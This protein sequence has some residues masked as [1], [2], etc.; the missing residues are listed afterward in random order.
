MLLA[1]ISCSVLAFSVFIQ[2]SFTHKTSE[3]TLVGRK[4]NTLFKN[5][6]YLAYYDIPY[7]EPPINE[8]RFKVKF[9]ALF[10]VL[11]LFLF[12]FLC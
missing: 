7:A 8:L 3:I 1:S 9:I 2:S 6:T 4:L 10:I 5:N 12:V 11:F